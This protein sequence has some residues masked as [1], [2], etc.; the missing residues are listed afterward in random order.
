M[1]T[2]SWGAASDCAPAVRDGAATE[3]P[4]ALPHPAPCT[5]RAPLLRGELAPDPITRASSATTRARRQVDMATLLTRSSR[6]PGRRGSREGGGEQLS[7]ANCNSRTP[8]CLLLRPHW[9]GGR[10]LSV[11]RRRQATLGC[12]SCI[13]SL[14]P[15][16]YS[17]RQRWRGG[18]GGVSQRSGAVRGRGGGRRLY[19][20]A[21]PQVRT[22]NRQTNQQSTLKGGG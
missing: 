12:S 11:L 9:W 15:E 14:A 2:G 8:G 22:G 10:A 4:A 16:G 1:H 7:I 18:R 3:P 17:H 21:P 5:L 19:H 20:A 6:L 13:S